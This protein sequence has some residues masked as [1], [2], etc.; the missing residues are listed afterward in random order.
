MFEGAYYWKEFCISKWVRHDNK[1]SLKHYENSLKQL[2]LIV[3]G[4]IFGRAYYQKDFCICDLGGLFRGGLFFWGEGG[5]F[6]E[7]YRI[8]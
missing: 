6:S 5:L 4:L 7:F 2:S 3:H 1:N 8:N